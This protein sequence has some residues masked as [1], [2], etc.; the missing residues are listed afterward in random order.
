MGDFKGE[1]ANQLAFPGK[2]AAKNKL[3]EASLKVINSYFKTQKFFRTLKSKIEF[4][5]R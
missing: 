4:A 3:G 1:A 5:T 2:E